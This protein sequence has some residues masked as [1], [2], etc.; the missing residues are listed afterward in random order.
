MTAFGQELAGTLR[1]A[2]VIDLLVRHI[3]ES[4]APTE[5]ALALFHRDTDA[6]AFAQ[7]W[8]PGRP[9]R[10]ALLELVERRG[11]L[12]LPDGLDPLVE[13]GDLPPQADGAG[14]WLVTPFVA[15]GRVT[16]AV[17]ICGERGRFGDPGAPAAGGPRQP[18]QH[19]PRERPP[20][21]SPR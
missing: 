17:A 18:G 11:P 10:R 21:G 8:P 9:D 3:R 14:S 15:R 13:Q 20:G 16:G 5:I 2:S 4:L 7:A 19:R 6:Q 12:T 1:R